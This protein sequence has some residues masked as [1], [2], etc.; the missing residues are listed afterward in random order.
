MKTRTEESTQDI[1][2]IW[3][4][5]KLQR[6]SSLREKLVLNYISL[7]R[8]VMKS[9]SIPANSIL[10]RD[11]LISSGIIGLIDAIEKYD[12]NRGV[13]FETYAVQRIKGAILDELRKV[14]W[15]SRTARQKVTE[16]SST[17]DSIQ[18]ETTTEPTFP[19]AISKLNIN[20]SEIN[21]YLL[22]YRSSKEGFFINETSFN[23]DDE[24]PTSFLENIPD[25]SQKSPLD[26]IVDEEKISIIMDYLNTLP[27]R[28][29]LIITLYY[30]EN[31][32]FKEIG[33]LL[34]ISESRVSQV[35]S[36]VIAQLKEK[37]KTIEE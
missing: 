25:E 20:T 9:I 3:K 29:R 31:L 18:N 27:E 23:G 37:F 7:V 13:K 5:Y 26:V 17:L 11:D 15:L 4:S 33:K 32:K 14:D 12:P 21:S 28:N 24:E 30:Y 10:T 19:E 22:A 8:S 6:D 2:G 34:N 1:K 16:I 36:E 35:H